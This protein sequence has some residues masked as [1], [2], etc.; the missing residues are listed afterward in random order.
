MRTAGRHRR[1]RRGM[2]AATLELENGELRQPA[3]APGFEL[4]RARRMPAARRDTAG[5][6]L[7]PRQSRRPRRALK[8]PGYAD[9]A[10]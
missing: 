5:S 2:S 6:W 1:L 4:H 8:G 7:S 10:G 9:K 3:R